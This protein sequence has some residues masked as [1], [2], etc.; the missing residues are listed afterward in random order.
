VTGDPLHSFHATTE[1]ADELSREQG[2]GAVPGAFVSF[3]GATVR[4]PVAVLAV[5]GA[6]IAWWHPGWRAVRVPAALF[7]CGVA[8]RAR[9]IQAGPAMQ[10]PVFLCLFLAPVYVPL[11][12]LTGWIHGVA[13]ANPITYFLEAGRG[14]ISG[15]PVYVLAAFAGAVGLVG[16]FLLWAALG[17]RRAEAAGGA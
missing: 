3:V 14:F 13:S 5:A 7:A 10:I 17:M 9:T 4:P 15:N 12:L 16:A 1:L 11:D 2:I 8:M 6:A